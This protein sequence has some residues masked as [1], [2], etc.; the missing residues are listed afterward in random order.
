VAQSD[1]VDGS[2]TEPSADRGPLRGGPAGVVDAP[3]ARVNFG[4]KQIAEPRECPR[5]Q[6][7]GSMS[8]CIS[9]VD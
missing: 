4:V 6:S 1:V 5:L 7:I 9:Y 8:H 3:D 2:S